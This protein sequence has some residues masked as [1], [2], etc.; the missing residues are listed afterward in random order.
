MATGFPSAQAYTTPPNSHGVHPIQHG[1]QQL[2]PSDSANNTPMDQ[3]PLSPNPSNFPTLPS[4]AANCAHQSLPCT[5]P[6]LCDQRNVLIEQSPSPL[7]EAFTAAPTAWNGQDSRAV[8]SAAAPRLLPAN[9][10]P[11]IKSLKTKPSSTKQTTPTKP[12]TPT[13]TTKKMIPTSPSRR[14]PKP[15]ALETRL[16]RPHL[17]RSYMP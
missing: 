16:K 13:T 6:L 2:S 10:S 15:R 8:Q 4:A 7:L 1:L 5:C 3:S 14:H 12:T 11:S 9:A 17:R